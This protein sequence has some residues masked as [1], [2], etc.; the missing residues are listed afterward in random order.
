MRWQRRQPRG[1]ACLCPLRAD[2]LPRSRCGVRHRRRA[3]DASTR[4]HAVIDT[5]DNDMTMYGADPEQLTALGNT[6]SAQ[7]EVLHQVTGTV[8]RVITGTVWQGT[9]RQRFEQDWYG[10]F[11]QVLA[12]L[13]DALD[14]AGHDFVNRS[15]E[16]SRIMGG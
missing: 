1:R 14:A 6:L 12:R 13:Q 3:G 7:I 10:S 4:T 16:L 5:E 2:H 9:A 11:T 8:E 15:L